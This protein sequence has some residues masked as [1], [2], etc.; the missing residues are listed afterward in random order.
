MKDKI[1]SSELDAALDNDPVDL[2][3]HESGATL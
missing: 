2:V 3:A 1:A